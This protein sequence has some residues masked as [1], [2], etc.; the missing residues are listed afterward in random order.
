MIRI[1]KATTSDASLLN[2]I[3][4]DAWL[5]NYPNP[6]LGIT[7][8]DL[9]S[10]TDEWKKL[11]NDRLVNKLNE[12]HTKTWVAKEGNEI[13]G[14][15]GIKENIN[16]TVI[17]GLFI[18]PKHQRKGIGSMLLKHALSKIK[19]K[20]VSLEVLFH[21]QNAIN[22]YQSFGFTKQEQLDK[23]PLILP[24]GKKIHSILMTKE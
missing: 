6:E 2:Q 13:L 22:F 16:Q 15:I 17:E 7:K 20:K 19:N 10:K 23:D 21:N 8:E 1:E 4:I 5:H 18:S 11:G 12:E 9:E 14:F 3:Q 24:S